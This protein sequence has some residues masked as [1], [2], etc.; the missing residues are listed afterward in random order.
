MEALADRTGDKEGRALVCQNVGEAW[1]YLGNLDKA[2]E[3]LKKA[4]EIASQM[5]K[6]GYYRS[7]TKM[8][9]R[10]HYW[11]NDLEQ[12]RKF[13]DLY[14]TRLESDY[15]ECSDLGLSVEELLTR[16]STE[17][18][19]VLYNLFCWSYFTGRFEAARE[20][21]RLMD[22][23]RGMCWWCD[24]DGC[25]ELMEARGFLLM[26]DH[27]K[28]EALE[29]FLRADQVIWLGCNKDARMAVK[30]LEKET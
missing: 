17:S 22:R 13:G 8:L 9:I 25:T 14:R 27:K 26:L 7:L 21:F 6:Y 4:Y 3:Y 16:P 20:Y 2:L 10:T 18:R 30:M 23:E 15:T 11:R 1:Y 24:E 28:D 5:K 19:Q 29:A 12:A